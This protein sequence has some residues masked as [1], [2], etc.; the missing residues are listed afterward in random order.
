MHKLTLLTFLMVGLISLNAQGVKQAL[1]QTQ[2]STEV[3][4]EAQTETGLTPTLRKYH[5]YW[6]NGVIHNYYGGPYANALFQYIT[7]VGGQKILTDGELT[8]RFVGTN[9]QLTQRGRAFFSHHL[10]LK[11]S[12]NFYAIYYNGFSFIWNFEEDQNLGWAL[13]NSYPN[14][15]GKALIHK[16][17]VLALD[18]QKTW[19]LAAVG[20]WAQ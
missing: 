15:W 19:A 5:V 4:A 17:K 3:E 11:Y 18:G 16:G 20:Y 13:Y 12:S 1:A 10:I 7:A 8:Q 6:W 2:V 9:L 14:T